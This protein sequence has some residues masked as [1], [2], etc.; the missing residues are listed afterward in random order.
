MRS[1]PWA[2]HVL[3]LLAGVFL[4]CR[5]VAPENMADFSDA[6]FQAMFLG[7]G[8][9]MTSVLAT[10]RTYGWMDGWVKCRQAGVT[11]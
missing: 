8:N 11:D 6:A 4:L 9:G 7:D 10:V 1:P 3:L 5:L 2:F